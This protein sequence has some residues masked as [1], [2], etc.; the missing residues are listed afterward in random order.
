MQGAVS[1]IGYHNN[2]RHQY[3]WGINRGSFVSFFFLMSMFGVGE[4]DGKRPPAEALD[5]HSLWTSKPTTPSRYAAVIIHRQERGKHEAPFTVRR[6]VNTD[7]NPPHE[8]LLACR[9]II[10]S[11]ACLTLSPRSSPPAQKERYIYI[12][13]IYYTYVSSPSSSI[14]IAVAWRVARSMSHHLLSVTQSS[15]TYSII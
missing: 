4:I 6:K 5:V 15:H 1:A 12:I 10:Y 9:H 7:G 14:Y 8:R 3:C 13:Y 11:L 2:E